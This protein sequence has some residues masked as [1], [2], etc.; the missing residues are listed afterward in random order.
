M[1][2]I[3]TKNNISSDCN[4]SMIALIWTSPVSNLTTKNKVDTDVNNNEE[5]Q[6]FKTPK[7]K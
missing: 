4:A 2:Y 7:E 3:L 6:Y 1:I 5:S